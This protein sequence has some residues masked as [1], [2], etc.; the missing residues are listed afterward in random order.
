VEHF[1][2]HRQAQTFLSGEFEVDVLGQTS[3]YQ[4]CF[5]CYP[6]GDEAAEEIQ[7]EVANT[8]LT[9]LYRDMADAGI[10]CVAVYFG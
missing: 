4:K 8:R 6:T 2:S 1:G 5:A 3:R 10:Q 9:A 7:V